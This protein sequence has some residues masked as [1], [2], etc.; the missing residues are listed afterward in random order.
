MINKKWIENRMD[1][2]A[3]GMEL[4]EM[5]WHEMTRH[6]MKWYETLWNESDDSECWLNVGRW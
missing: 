6:V 3:N 2:N 4:N 5:I 1:G